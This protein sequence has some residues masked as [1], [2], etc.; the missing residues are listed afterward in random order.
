[1]MKHQNHL[2]T[3]DVYISM[4][5]DITPYEG[6]SMIDRVYATREAAQKRVDRMNLN[7]GDYGEYFKYDVEKHTVYGMEKC[8]KNLSDE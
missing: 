8:N 4:F 6:Y 2:T 1:M 5:Y 3:S 7:M